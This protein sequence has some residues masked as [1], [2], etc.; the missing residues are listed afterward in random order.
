MK[1][2]RKG[3]DVWVSIFDRSFTD[4]YGDRRTGTT[5]VRAIQDH[6][7]WRIDRA[8]AVAGAWMPWEAI[9]EVSYPSAATAKRAVADWLAGEHATVEREMHSAREGDV[10]PDETE[11]WWESMSPGGV[12]SITKQLKLTS[13]NSNQWNAD[14]WEKVMHYYVVVELD[15]PRGYSRG[16]NV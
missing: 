16:R 7:G 8:D 9:D 13:K 15:D 11:E 14:D 10:S 12:A 1:W 3:P 4:I 5:A 2:E 6:R